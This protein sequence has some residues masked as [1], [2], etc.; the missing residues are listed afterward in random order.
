M[1]LLTTLVCERQFTV[2]DCSFDLPYVGHYYISVRLLHGGE[3]GNGAG[4][5]KRQNGRRARLSQLSACPH[6]ML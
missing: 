2:R 1:L 4:M 6:L 5:V 3:G